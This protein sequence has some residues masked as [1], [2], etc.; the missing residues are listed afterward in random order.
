MHKTI[1][2][3]Y[4]S[5]YD[6]SKFTSIKAGLA[7]R[8]APFKR[9][10]RRITFN[11]VQLRYSYYRQSNGLYAHIISFAFKAERTHN[12]RFIIE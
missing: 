8:Y 2:E 7:L 12:K 5:D 3:F 4:T 11:E 1:D 6:L 10:G 9:V